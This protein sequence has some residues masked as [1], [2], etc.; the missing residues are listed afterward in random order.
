MLQH[1][2]SNC[3]FVFRRSVIFLRMKIKMQSL[4]KMVC[5]LELYVHSVLMNKLIRGITFVQFQNINK[6]HKLIKNKVKMS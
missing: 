6:L 1:Q 2:I 5:S 3:F 4:G